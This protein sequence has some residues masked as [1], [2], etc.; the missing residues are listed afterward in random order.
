[1]TWEKYVRERDTL[2]GEWAQT[3]LIEKVVGVDDRKPDAHAFAEAAAK[4][5]KLGVAYGLRLEFEAGNP[6]G[7][8]SIR[9]FGYAETRG[10][11]GKARQTEWHIGYLSEELAAELQK[12][13]I[14]AGLPISAELLGIFEEGEHL[15][16]S[17]IV[18]APKGF[19][20]G[21]RIQAM[22]ASE[23]IAEP[24][25]KKI[26]RL[27]N[28]KNYDEAINLL[29][30]CCDAEEASSRSTKQGVAPWCYE[31]LAK[32]FRKLKFRDEEIAILKR[33]QQ[34]IKAADVGSKKLIA[35][36]EKL[37]SN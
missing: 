15:D 18:L 8:N 16:F 5:E 34:Q 1:M 30:D 19:E 14:S 27:I 24:P 28:E 21:V 29:L 10:W 26:S 4:A 2:V 3:T 20:R 13:V 25:A 11:I 9:V 6:R 7:S 17:L 32:L 31:E 23:K 22:R 33:Y 36:M 37:L 12:D 35:R